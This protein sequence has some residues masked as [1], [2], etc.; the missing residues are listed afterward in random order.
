MA[1]A[2]SDDYLCAEGVLDV[3]LLHANYANGARGVYAFDEKSQQVSIMWMYTPVTGT[4]W[5]TKKFLELAKTWKELGYET[6]RIDPADGTP[7]TPDRS[8]YYFWPKMGFDGRLSNAQLR[9][10]R[11][12][13]LQ[14]CGGSIA[15]LMGLIGGPEAWK[16]YG[17]RLW[18]LTFD[19]REGSESWKRIL[20]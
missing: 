1:G 4:G 8:G 7:R 11:P 3:L 2:S 20:N 18:N 6:I 12:L 19:L 9:R 13:W 17:S 16:K 14:E 10:L 15:N 5:G